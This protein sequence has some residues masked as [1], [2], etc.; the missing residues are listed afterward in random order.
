MKPP[1]KI[2]ERAILKKRPC[3]HCKN[4]IYLQ[5]M[6]ITPKLQCW[7]SFDSSDGKLHQCLVRP[8]ALEVKKLIQAAIYPSSPATVSNIFG[9]KVKIPS[10]MYAG[11]PPNVVVLFIVNTFCGLSS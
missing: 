11:N 2:P 8:L 4:E 1:T 3:K 10:S 5:F 6:K 7:I 9:V